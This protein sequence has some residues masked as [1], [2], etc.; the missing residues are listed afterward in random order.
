MPAKAGIYDFSLSQQGK[1]WIP[2]VAGKTTSAAPVG[3]CFRYLVL[4]HCTTNRSNNCGAR[5]ISAWVA[6]YVAEGDRI[7]HDA[8]ADLLLM[9][10][11]R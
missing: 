4:P 7:R 11:P 3:Q 8:S 2:A 6:L 5:R 9:R 1:P 10:I